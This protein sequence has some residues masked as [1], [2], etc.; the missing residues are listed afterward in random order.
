MNAGRLRHRLLIQEL[1]RDPAVGGVDTYQTHVT[2]W[3]EMRPTSGR[4]LVAAQAENAEIS[5]LFT[6][7]YLR[8]IRPTMRIL[9]EG[10]T[11]QIVAPPI[12]FEEQHR[13]LQ[14]A[15]KEVL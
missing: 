2:V 4:E 1:V 6:I 14:L 10:R 9:F 3:G 11:F 5:A 15:V 8:G 13:E 12:D 7:R